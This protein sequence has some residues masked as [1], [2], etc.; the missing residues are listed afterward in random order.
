V[1]WLVTGVLFL[2]PFLEPRRPFRGLHLD[3]IVLLAFGALLVRIFTSGGGIWVYRTAV[4]CVAI[5]LVYV[6]VRMLAEGLRPG[7]RP[8]AL[9]PLVP[10]RWLAIGAVA[11]ALFHVGYVVANPRP[12]VDVGQV[13]V[14]GADR[15]IRGQGL[16]DVPFSRRYPHGDT[17]GPANYLLYVPFQ[18]ALPSTH[19][20]GHMVAA[21]AAA[22]TF[23]LLT[24]LGLFLLGWRLR[25]PRGRGELGVALTFAWFSYPY[26][27]FVAAY[28]FNDALVALLLVMALLV[29]TSPAV[30]G[31][32]NAIGSAVKFA[33]A[34]LVP[35]FATATGR[36]NL[37]SW[38]LF[39]AVF[40]AVTAAQFLP[41]MPD[42][43]LR[44]LYD[45]TIGWQ[46]ARDP[47]GS[48]W[49]LSSSLHPGQVA[50]RGVAVALAILVAFVPRRKTPVQLAALGA[51]VLATFELGLSYW[52]PSYIVWFAPFAFLALFRSYVTTPAAVGRA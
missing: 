20:N 32:A 26:T 12:V 44:E 9:V 8:E 33:S 28:S 40:A 15:I 39:V 25:P 48:V 5:G 30:S 24:G 4:V 36:R 43:G 45:R 23:D 37:R 19:S 13:S 50:V 1:V 18:A 31:A 38:A 6:L 52:I 17:Y 16:Y 35:L 51:A 27:L 3:L 47:A 46:A 10:I 14:L 29:V 2:V 22:L 41:F 34:A 11:M 21:R 42:G 7:S 49:A